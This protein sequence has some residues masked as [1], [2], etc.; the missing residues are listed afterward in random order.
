MNHSTPSQFSLRKP[1]YWLC[2]ASLTL[3]LAFSL[4]ACGSL[5][6]SSSIV[7]SASDETPA[8]LYS[9]AKEQLDRSNWS[10]AIESMEKV[11][12]ADTL[13]IYGQK[14]L[15]DSA[16]AQ[17]K[18]DEPALALALVERY[19]RIFPKSEGMPYALYLKGLI[20]F[21][22]NTDMLSLLNKEDLS[23]RDPQSL[24]DSYDSFALLS[25]NYPNSPY[26][27][28]ANERIP[29]L[30]KTLAKHELNIALF[31]LRNNAPIAAIGRAQNLLTTYPQ[32]S[33][34]EE[35]LGLMAEAYRQTNMDEA[36]ENTLKVLKENY[37]NSI[38]LLPNASILYKAPA[39][40]WFKFW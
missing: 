36:R 16:Y 34:Q 14:A 21:D 10:A 20:N 32:A 6:Q 27:Q 38:H 4:T 7:L 29:F 22:R 12:N 37:P 26:A 40:S 28:E 33:L 30:L 5:G 13:G 39:K 1:A 9:Q 25:K 23:E 18:D 11:Q 2:T 19:L 15:L 35:A 24:K 17:W 3:S 31:Y 8:M